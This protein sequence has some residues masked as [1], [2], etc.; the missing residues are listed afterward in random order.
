[1]ES[2]V[3]YSIYLVIY[4][5][6]STKIKLVLALPAGIVQSRTS[7]R[8]SKPASRARSAEKIPVRFSS[9]TTG[10]SSARMIRRPLR[11]TRGPLFAGGSGKQTIPSTPLLQWKFE[12]VSH[13]GERQPKTGGEILWKPRK[14]SGTPPFAVSVRR[15]TAG[16]WSLWIP[17]VV[18]AGKMSSD[19]KINRNAA[20]LY[21]N[22]KYPENQKVNSFY[23]VSA[24]RT[25]LEL[26]SSRVSELESERKSS[27]KKLDCFMRRIEEEKVSWRRKEHAKIKSIVEAMKFELNGERKRTQRLKKMNS[28]LLN[29]LRAAKLSAKQIWQEYERERK[30]CAIL[31]EVCNEIANEIGDN[32]AEVE[33]MKEESAKNREQV[34]EER[35]M[36]QLAEVWREERV[37]MKLIDAKITLEEKYS[38]VSKLEEEIEDFLRS[39][40]GN[41]HDVSEMNQAES[42]KEAIESAKNQDLIEFSPRAPPGSV[43]ILQILEGIEERPMKRYDNMM[44]DGNCGAEDERWWEIVGLEEEQGSSKS[45]GGSEPSVNGRFVKSR[46]L[47]W[48]THDG[49]DE[50]QNSEISEICSAATR[51]SRKKGSSMSRLWKSSGAN[52][53]EDYKKKSLGS[54]YLQKPHSMNE[55]DLMGKLMEEGIQS[56]KV[57]I[58]QILREKI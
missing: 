56:Q 25:E 28:K 18:V 23:I 53:A 11:R 13:S 20:N 29:E 21:D 55:Q 58:R 24:L 7:E 48:S 33:A 38:Q 41:Q 34:E 31:N 54:P 35:K 17:K 43:G 10:I 6:A 27:K 32:E 5:R 51:L 1:M 39:R 45:P 36:M 2:Q 9:V 26:A 57:Q 3:H 52:K 46:A 16:I 4:I 40:S 15:L 47:V 44:F 50:K 22:P 14:T 30:A 42:L 12:E 37:Q 19:L 49:D 8:M